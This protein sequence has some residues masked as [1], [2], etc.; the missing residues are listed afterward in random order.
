MCRDGIIIFP[1]QALGSNTTDLRSCEAVLDTA[2]LS[3]SQNQLIFVKF[4]LCLNRL[5]STNSFASNVCKV[6]LLDTPVSLLKL[7]PALLD[8]EPAVV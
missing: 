3:V 4:M 8:V 2:P 6:F 7:S 1:V 5:E